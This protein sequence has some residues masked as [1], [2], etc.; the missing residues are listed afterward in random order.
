MRYFKKPLNICIFIRATTFHNK[1][2]GLETQNRVLAEGLV[3]NGHKVI[4]ISTSLSNSKKNY[5]FEKGV[6]YYF[7]KSPLGI[8]SSKWYQESLN[9]FKIFIKRESFDVL[10]SQSSAGK[11]VFKSV[12]DIRKVTINH[13]TSFGE[14]KNR[15]KTIKSFRNIGR[16]LLKDIPMWF[17][18]RVEDREIFKA[19]DLIVCVSSILA[20]QVKKEFPKFKEKVV[21]VDNG[22]EVKRFKV[23]DS[24]LKAKKNRPIGLLYIGRIDREKGIEI[25]L[26]AFSILCR[27]S[28]TLHLNLVGFGPHLGEF[29][30]LSKR[31]GIDDVV[32]FVGEVSNDQTPK[33]YKQAD[34]FI[35][36]SLRQEGFPMVL[37]EAMAASLPIIASSI[38]GIPSAVKNNTNGLLVKPKSVESLS[39]ALESLVVDK[40]LRNELSEGSRRFSK[41]KYSQ[42]IMIKK[43]I[44]YIRLINPKY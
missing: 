40:K 2:G 22:V 12:L 19:S 18:G 3:K 8:Y 27:K 34:I 43:Y 9:A 13:G 24:R 35:L 36:P 28:Y 25:L 38:G 39:K 7:V 23:Q 31:L 1:S 37:A 4:V 44:K 14:I 26:K 33:Y 32:T 11:E 6:G 29:R 30:N 5:L 16:F 10:I 17:K 42:D 20:D 15:F 41:A 21:V